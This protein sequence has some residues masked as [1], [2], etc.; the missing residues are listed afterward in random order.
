[1]NGEVE[2]NSFDNNCN[3]C[4][5]S[6]NYVTKNKEAGTKIDGSPCKE[7]DGNGGE[8]NKEDGKTVE[9][10]ECKVCQDGELTDVEGCCPSGETTLYNNR[11][12][13][14]SATQTFAGCCP[15]E[16]LVK[17]NVTAASLF[18][19]KY[20]EGTATQTWSCC[21]DD[22]GVVSVS[23]YCCNED[24][25]Y[26]DGTKCC[27]QGNANYHVTNDVCCTTT[28]TGHINQ[29]GTQACCANT[30]KLYPPEVSEGGKQI[31]CTATQKGPESEDEALKCC[32]NTQFLYTSP[33]D[34]TKGICCANGSTG[35]INQNGTQAC[36]AKGSTVYP[37]KP[38]ADQKQICC[39]ATQEG[40]EQ[41]GD[42][43]LCC[44]KTTQKRYL[45]ADRSDA[46]CCA[47]DAKGYTDKNN[48]AQ[49][50]P[51]GS[52]LIYMDDGSVECG[53]CPWL[54]GKNETGLCIVATVC[55]GWITQDCAG[56]NKHKYSNTL[57]RNSFQETITPSSDMTI[58]VGPF[59]GL[60]IGGT[61]LYNAINQSTR[62]CSG[63]L[64]KYSN[65]MPNYES[66]AKVN[67]T[68]YPITCQGEEDMPFV[69][70]A[71]D[72][73]C[74]KAK[75]DCKVGPIHLKAGQKYNID[76]ELYTYC[77]NQDIK[78]TCE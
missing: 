51:S 44:N 62:S 64:F 73:V 67:G 74:S 42:P 11:K 65:Y 10:D 25:L 52:Q 55:C 43:L 60:V 78:V 13:T 66:Y 34:K 31:C 54:K 46:K 7:C 77:T 18:K 63:S 14:A 23:P 59:D 5:S 68:R 15:D 28:Q 48:K 50:C 27:Y 57:Y 35:H 38:G 75:V 58:E 56:G 8:R 37:S 39:T 76:I 24:R 2:D 29:N 69:T 12:T 32:S 41:A 47:S 71:N 4:N 53:S 21:G 30:S 33:L 61:A 26:A 49:C 72:Q 17:G 3:Y 19:N 9:G 1:M 22:Q 45:T 36:C 16:K 6:T 40:P 20:K 70:A